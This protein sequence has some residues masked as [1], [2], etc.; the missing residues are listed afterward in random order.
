MRWLLC[1]VLVG[2]CAY[3]FLSYVANTTGAWLLNGPQPIISIRCFCVRM[4]ESVAAL[5]VSR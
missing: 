5:S 4:S 1:G 2:A 3:P